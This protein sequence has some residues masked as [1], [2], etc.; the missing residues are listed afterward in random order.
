MLKKKRLWVALLLAAL[1]V[2]GLLLWTS[3]RYVVPIVMYHSIQDTAQLQ[4]QNAVT[5]SPK[6]FRY[7][8][9][10][11]KKNKYNV[12][13]VDELVSGIQAGKHFPR[14]TVVIT[15]DDGFLDNYTQAFP[16]LKEYRYPAAMFVIAK[17]IGKKEHVRWNQV[18]EMVQS[19]LITIGS[20]SYTHA[21]L[22]EIPPEQ[23]SEEIVKSK[24]VLEAR[25]GRPVDYFTYPVGGFNA[26]ISELTAQAGYKGAFTTNRG[27]NRYNKNVY[28]L[29]RIRLSDKDNSDTILWF[30]LSGFYNLFRSEKPSE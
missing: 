14:R 30:K 22:P 19:G 13:T 10:F 15:F 24:E 9:D 12:I 29:K 21:Y 3:Q 6:F 4:L 7:H 1:L 23:Q 11:L 26:Q 16:I 20:H 8:L 27:Y 18:V 25:I 17:Y 5:T 28:A 2:G